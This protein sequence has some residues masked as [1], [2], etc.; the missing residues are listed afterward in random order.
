MKKLAVI[1]SLRYKK[2]AVILLAFVIIFTVHSIYLNCVAEDAYVSFRFANN[3]ANGEGFVWNSGE[4][5]VEGYT[6]FLWVVIMAVITKIG[7]GVEAWSQILGIA[8]SILAFYYVYSLSMLIDEGKHSF[9]NFIA[10]ALMAI[11]GPIATWAS[12]GMETNLF[13]LFIIM[14]FY[15]F[16]RDEKNK[17]LTI[18]SGI[19]VLFASLTRPEGV[20]VF[21]IL[22][23]YYIGKNFRRNN[24]LRI[25][26][27]F[28]KWL[29]VFLVPGLIYFLWRYTY[30]GFLLPNTFYAKVG[31]TIY[32]VKR[33][34][35]YI[36]CYF[37]I[38]LVP[39]LFLLPIFITTLTKNSK[40]NAAKM[41]HWIPLLLT[42]LAYLMYVVYIGG[43]YMA[44]FRFIVPIIPLIYL[45]IQEL[46]RIGYHS[47]RGVQ[48]AN[49]SLLVVLSLFVIIPS[50]DPGLLKQLKFPGWMLE[51][52]AK[53][54]FM[55]GYKE[56][57]EIERW[58]SNRLVVIGKFFKIY[59][60]PGESL[61]TNAVGAISFYSGIKIYDTS[62]IVDTHIAHIHNP[63]MG[64]GF[65]GHEKGDYEYLL[66][67]R[68]TYI[69]VTRHLYSRRLKREDF[70]KHFSE[71]IQ[72]TYLIHY[73][74]V[75]K[76]LFDKKNRERGYFVFFE[77]RD[78]EEDRKGFITL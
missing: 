77:L 6:N 17:R 47:G 44:M 14:S 24:W 56:G 5:P 64:K 11:S 18:T 33:G 32:Q 43:D 34:F 74:V 12:S 36:F 45:L 46:F 61:L 48:R 37:K 41:S 8:A 72:R 1:Q 19:Y 55:H 51:Y 58:H 69:M 13:M 22:S 49:I 20:M 71:H 60:K 25:D 31:G 30:Y 40:K 75:Y 67:K 29:L 63:D 68:P 15:Y 7:L 28:L 50:V 27:N 66:K 42:V 39:V 62:G 54:S 16:F 57:V 2:E 21:V 9:I 76:K 59:A 38:F 35:N 70:L 3:L 26:K 78:K 10:V 4:R 52:Y 65:P 53:P 23:A 73:R